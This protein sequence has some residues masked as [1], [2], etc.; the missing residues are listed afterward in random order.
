MLPGSRGSAHTCFVIY[1][2]HSNGLCKKPE[3][4]DWGLLNFDGG[5]TSGEWAI[6]QKET[7]PYWDTLPSFAIQECLQ[8]RLLQV[9]RQLLFSRVSSEA[10]EYPCAFRLLVIRSSPGIISSH[11]SKLGYWTP[12]Q[13]YALRFSH[14]RV[15][16][17]LS[18]PHTGAFRLA[19][20]TH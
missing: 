17:D 13:H 1:I 3:W 12:W 2:S 11:M 4:T 19:G 15:V 10:L 14:R 9:Q 16:C 6:N 20:L 7:K 5:S 18:F 8:A